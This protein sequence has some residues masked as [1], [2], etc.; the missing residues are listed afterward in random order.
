[1][2]DAYALYLRARTA[3]TSAPARRRLDYTIA[4]TGIDGSAARSNHYRA[5]L[6]GDDVRVAAMSLEEAAQPPPQPHGMNWSLSVFLCQAHCETGS[7][8][9]HLP[10]GRTPPSPDLLGVPLLTPSYTFG[11]A[12][13]APVRRTVDDTP[14]SPLPTIAIVATKRRDYSVE[15]LDEPDVDG[16]PTY[17]LRLTPLRDPKNLRLRELWIGQTDYLPRRAIVAGNFTLA[18]MVDVPWTVSFA[19]AGG[20]PYVATERADAELRLPHRRVVRDAAI[21]FE[22]VREPSGSI[23]DAPVI[24]PDDNGTA[25]L[26][27]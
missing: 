3:V 24:A 11:L 18:P 13:P 1:M 16:A 21:A 22:N 15:L 10:V 27:P 17:H 2:P 19:V 23:F 6:R 7:F 4:V 5:S 8:T 9:Y 14:D 20:Y 12:Y 25:L 26:E